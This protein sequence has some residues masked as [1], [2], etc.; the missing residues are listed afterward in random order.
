MRVRATTICVLLAGFAATAFAADRL[1]SGPT[2]KEVLVATVQD[3]GKPF[4]AE[5]EHLP[6]AR[7]SGGAHAAGAL[8]PRQ[9]RCL[10]FLQWL[11]RL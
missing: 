3:A 6:A 10:Q 11:A 8:H 1:P 2:Y 4:A 9:R 7:R 5:N